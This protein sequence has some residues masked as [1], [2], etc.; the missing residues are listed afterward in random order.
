MSKLIQIRKIN[1]M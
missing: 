1:K